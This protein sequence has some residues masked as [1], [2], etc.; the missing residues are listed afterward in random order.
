MRRTSIRNKV[1]FEGL[2]AFPLAAKLIA[3]DFS[4][5]RSRRDVPWHLA[6][7]I[8]EGTP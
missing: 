5:R 3:H 4:G 2:A 7:H 1:A 6:S 8:S